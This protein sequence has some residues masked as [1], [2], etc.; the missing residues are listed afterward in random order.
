MLFIQVTCKHQG[1]TPDK[2][3]KKTYEETKS[4]TT[5]LRPS[6]VILYQSSI[7]DHL[8]RFN[9]QTENLNTEM[10]CF[11]LIGRLVKGNMHPFEGMVNNLIN[12]IP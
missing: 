3:K 4:C 10:N 12:L 9:M 5:A 6:P 7:L 2:N 11:Q 8:M 1:I